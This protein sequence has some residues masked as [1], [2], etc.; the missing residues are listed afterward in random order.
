M[1]SSV[2][3]LFLRAAGLPWRPLLWLAGFIAAG[4]ALERLTA[5]VHVARRHRDPAG[6]LFVPL[7]LLRDAVWALAIVVWSARRIAGRSRR[8]WHSMGQG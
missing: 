8:P 5:G 4:L 3:A 7:H 6:L 2:A 1:A